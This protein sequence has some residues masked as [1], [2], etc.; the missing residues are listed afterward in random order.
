[1]FTKNARSYFDW[2][3]GLGIIGNPHVPTPYVT[4]SKPISAYNTI[5]GT[6]IKSIIQKFPTKDVATG[7]DYSTNC[8]WGTI[9]GNGT[10]TPSIE[11][12]KLFGDHLTAL[13]SS[14]VTVSITY[15]ANDNDSKQSLTAVYT[16]TNTTAKDL[17]ISEMGLTY[18]VYCKLSNSYE[19]AYAF[20]LE[21]AVLDAPVTIPVGGVGQVTYTIEM[22]Y[23]TF[24]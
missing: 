20:L 7:N 21:H 11:D 9:F 2:A 18:E 19:Y 15:E 13:T 1:M 6:D 24:Q 12:T 8:R 17:T 5:Y 23:P 4:P 3:L 16:I 14:N 22:D 10:G